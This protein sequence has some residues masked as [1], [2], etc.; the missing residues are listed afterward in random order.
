MTG[1]GMEELFEAVREAR[2]EYL[3]DYKPQ[4][5]KVVREREEKKEKEKQGSMER[6]LSDMK[7]DKKGGR[8]EVDPALEK[9]LDPNQGEEEDDEDDDEGEII[10]ASATPSSLSLSPNRSN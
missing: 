1:D 6:M 2:Q 3:D 8:D 9:Y 5:D 4:L 7:L 10:D